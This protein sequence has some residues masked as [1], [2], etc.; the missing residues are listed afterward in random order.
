[1]KEVLATPTETLVQYGKAGRAAVLERHDVRL[2][3]ASLKALL[4]Q[5]V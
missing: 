5:Y 3:A 4:E 2:T 1:M